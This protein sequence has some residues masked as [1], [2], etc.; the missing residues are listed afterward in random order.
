MSKVPIQKGPIV[1]D[2]KTMKSMTRAEINREDAA[3][4]KLRIDGQTLTLQTPK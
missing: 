4:A 2:Q 1:A 3:N